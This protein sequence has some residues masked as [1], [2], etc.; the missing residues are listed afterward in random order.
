MVDVVHRV[1]FVRFEHYRSDFAG[2]AKN[3]CRANTTKQWRWR[4][5]GLRYVQ[6]TLQHWL[7]R[8]LQ[9]PNITAWRI[10]NSIVNN[11]NKLYYITGG[12][13]ADNNEAQQLLTEVINT[14][15]DIYYNL[16][17]AEEMLIRAEAND[18]QQAA[19]LVDAYVQI[20]AA[21]QSYNDRQAQL[22]QSG[23]I[24]SIQRN[25]QQAWLWL[26][27]KFSDVTGIGIEP[28]TV[29]IVAAVMVAGAVTAYVVTQLRAMRN[30]QEQD[31]NRI[32]FAQS[33]VGE[34]IAANPNIDTSDLSA[35]INSTGFN[36]A[37]KNSALDSIL[38]FGKWLLVGG[39][40]LGAYKVFQD[41]RK[42]KTT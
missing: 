33:V 25:V 7:Q 18:T 2:T 4:W 41:F 13:G 42:P 15:Q 20:Q 27:R 29:C 16:I 9:L 10:A 22:A 12:I 24:T 6:S 34:Y 31:L 1:G 5:R 40:A 23:W 21:K 14:D 30:Q 19:L 3:R 35:L 36:P 11:V 26:A 8:R 32:G 37:G 28:I 17:L 38:S 39:M